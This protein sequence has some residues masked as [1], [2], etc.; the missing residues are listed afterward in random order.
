M[1]NEEKKVEELK[2]P[3]QIEIQ[4]GQ[5]KAQQFIAKLP[6][7]EGK[8]FLFVVEHQEK[9]HCNL[10][11]IVKGTDGFVLALVEGLLESRPRVAQ[12]VI[13]AIMEKILGAEAVTVNSVEELNELIQKNTGEIPTH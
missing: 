4:D 1:N 2:R 9:E 5:D 6:E 8:N 7:L 11:A 3:I 13:T 10:E 12:Y